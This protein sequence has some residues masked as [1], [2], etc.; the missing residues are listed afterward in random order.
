MK[1][2]FFTFI[3]DLKKEHILNELGPEIALITPGRWDYFIN[4][5]KKRGYLNVNSADIRSH[6]Q[7]NPGILKKLAELEKMQDW[8]RIEKLI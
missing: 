4:W 1:K 2:D 5:A 8:E 3:E 6:F 7:K